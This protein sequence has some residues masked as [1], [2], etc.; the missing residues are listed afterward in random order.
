MDCLFPQKPATHNYNVIVCVLCLFVPPQH[1]HPYIS[2][3][4]N[5]GTL[6]YDHDRDG[7]HT[8]LAGC[9]VQFRNKDYET[10]VAIRY[11]KQRLT[12]SKG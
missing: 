6:H 10:Q 3:Q 1:A 9:P 7:T 5:N 12:V 8:E 2:A 11:Y 4:I